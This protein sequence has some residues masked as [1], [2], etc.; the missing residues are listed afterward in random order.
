ML[1]LW[2]PAAALAGGAFTYAELARLCPEAGGEYNYLS[3]LSVR[4]L[5]SSPAGF[6]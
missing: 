4:W 6:P 1:L 3:T 5:V 2:W